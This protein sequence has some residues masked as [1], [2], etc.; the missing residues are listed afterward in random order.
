VTLFDL[1]ES[2]GMVERADR[3]Y[4]EGD[5]AES[6]RLLEGW[7]ANVPGDVEARW[8]AARAS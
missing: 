1:S 4:W 7:L 2:P 6:L 5:A 3:A 8:R